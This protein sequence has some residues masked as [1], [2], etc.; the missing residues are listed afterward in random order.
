MTEMANPNE[1]MRVEVRL[2]GG[3]ECRFYYVGFNPNVKQA[4][5][6]DLLHHISHPNSVLSIAFSPDGKY[7]ATGSNW[8]VTVFEVSTGQIY[9]TLKIELDEPRP[10]N[11]A[12]SL[13]FYPNSNVL[14][15]GWADKYIRFWDFDTNEILH[16]LEDPDHP[17]LSVQV[18]PT[19]RYILAQGGHEILRIWD[20]AYGK[21][22]R[23]VELN[24]SPVKVSLSP[25]GRR[26]AVLY[27]DGKVRVFNMP[28]GY[29]EPC[30]SGLDTQEHDI[31][32]AQ[33]PV[34]TRQLFTLNFDKTIKLWDLGSGGV[35]RTFAGHKGSILGAALTP[36]FRWLISGGNGD[37]I[38]FWDPDNGDMHMEIDGLDPKRGITLVQA[39]QPN[40]FATVGTDNSVR[41]WRYSAHKE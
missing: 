8:T 19:G 21:T 2:G 6:V 41:I 3:N 20:M 39:C 34:G 5:D 10:C 13:C 16:T 14:V 7:L 40:V 25:D 4:L 18:E 27:K 23:T 26:A 24:T 1:E 35:V 17:I 31:L 9:R 38:C 32:W 12:Y 37:T 30:L 29:P 11:H 36:D 28:Y 15:S 33:C 22:I